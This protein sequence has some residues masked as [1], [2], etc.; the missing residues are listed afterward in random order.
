MSFTYC[1]H[2]SDEISGTVL[3]QLAVTIADTDDLV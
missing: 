1:K 2:S 3:Q